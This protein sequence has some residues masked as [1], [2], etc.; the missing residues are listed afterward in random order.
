[1]CI[2]KNFALYGNITQP[3]TLSLTVT[4]VGPAS[5]VQVGNVITITSGSTTGL[6][7]GAVAENAALK[8]FR[9]Y[10]A[11]TASQNITDTVNSLIRVINYD[12][13]VAV[14]AILVSTTTDLPGQFILE[15]DNPYGTFTATVSANATAFDPTLTNLTSENKRGHKRDCSLQVR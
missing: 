12:S 7:T 9:I 11:G 8:Q 5:G 14:H 15:S 4:A 6:Y 3:S 10:T 2:F 13:T 1:M